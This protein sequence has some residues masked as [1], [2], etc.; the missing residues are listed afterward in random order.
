MPILITIDDLCR[1]LG[2]ADPSRAY[3]RRGGIPRELLFPGGYATPQT[4]ERLGIAELRRRGLERSDTELLPM[5]ALFLRAYPSLDEF[6]ASA[7][8]WR[9]RDLCHKAFGS[10]ANLDRMDEL[11][12]LLWRLVDR[13]GV[14]CER[15]VVEH[16][17]SAA[18][19]FG[20]EL[21]SGS[22]LGRPVV[23]GNP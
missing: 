5:Q 17:Q 20:Q 13:M 8:N 21:E 23:E 4:L 19:Q 6:E 16:N 1:F 2:D 10:D 3:R 18:Q 14:T 9:W 11:R 7:A 15:I 12:S 22:F